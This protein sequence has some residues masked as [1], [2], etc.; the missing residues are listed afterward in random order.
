MEPECD[1]PQ[2]VEGC[3]EPFGDMRQVL[4]VLAQRFRHIRLRRPELERQRDEPL[5][6]AVVQVPLD[7]APGRVGRDHDSCA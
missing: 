6:R 1:L 3:R 7:P 5:L 4:T 2:S